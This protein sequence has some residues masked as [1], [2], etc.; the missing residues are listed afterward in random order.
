M[1][2]GGG[3]SLERLARQIASNLSA[4]PARLRQ[5]FTV[6]E[7]R[8][9]I[10]PYRANRKALQF[11]TSEDYEL[12]LMQLCAGESGFG[13]MEAADVG[14]LFSDEIAS[15]NP[16]LSLLQQHEKAL[17]IL[18]LRSLQATAVRPDPH[19]A[20][21]PPSSPIRGQNTPRKSRKTPQ[22]ATPA[23][24]ARC[25]RCRESLPIGRMANFCPHCGFDLR[26]GHCP[27]CNTEVEPGWRHCVSCG[28]SLS[29]SS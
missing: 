25:G 20:F 12:A 17:L 1:R 2:D 14:R 22:V 6:A 9:L 11:E 28:T 7:L 18:D 27:Q 24:A 13:R 4:N 21:A 16:D 23:P 15:P 5:P 8:D 10:V 29:G 3:P 19:Q 26:R